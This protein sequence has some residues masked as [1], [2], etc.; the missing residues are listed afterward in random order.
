M[1]KTLIIIGSV[2]TLIIILMIAI[3]VIYKGKIAAIAKKTANNAVN[4]K[5]DFTDVDI[6]LFRHFPHL[7]VALKNLTVTGIGDFGNYKL[8]QA[9]ALSTSVNL[10][11]L[12]KKNLSIS[13]IYIDKPVLNLKV[14]KAG[15]SNWDI[16]KTDTTKTETKK[17]NASID[18]NK[19]HI[20]DASLTYN[21][22]GTPMSFSLSNA[23]FD[24][25]GKMKGSNST[26]DVKGK[27]D[28]LSFDYNGTNYIKNLK[29]AVEGQLKADFN[30]KVFTF[31][32]NQ[33]LI[34]KLPLEADGTFTL[35]EKDYDFDINFKSPAS[36]L[37]DLLG[38]I[39]EKYHSYV[40]D[41]QTQ[42]SVSFSGYFKG[43]YND[44]TFPGF[45]VDIKVNDGKLKYPKLPK[46]IEQINIAANINKA[47]GDMDLAK[48][49]VEKFE[50][51]LAGNPIDASLH[52]AT[53]VSDPLVKGNLKGKIDFTELKQAIPMDS[54][55]LGGIMEAFID[56]DGKYSSIEK[57]QYQDFKTTGKVTLRNFEY[58]SPSLTQRVKIANAGMDF[59]PKTI[60]LTNL[61]GS[62]GQSDFS[63]KG[64]LSNYWLYVMKKGTLSGDLNL[65]SRYLDFNVLKPKS[66]SSVKDTISKPFEVPDKINLT[67]NTAINQLVFDKLNISNVT[68]KA[69]V[70]DK[71]LILDGLNM[72]MLGGSMVMSG[73]YNTPKEQIPSFNLKMNV[74]NFDLP[75]AFQSVSTIR[76]LV[77]L[78]GESTGAFNT[79]LSI[80]GKIGKGYTPVFTSL[81]GDGLL[82]TKNVQIAGASIFN[83]ISKYF[84]KDLF[85]QVKIGDLSTRFKIVDGGLAVSPFTT[86]I[87]G[88]EVTVSGKQ[89]ASK[90]LSYRLDF[91]VNK[92]DLSQEVNKY[93]GFVPGTEN[94]GLI[95]V[96]IEINGTITKPDVKVDMSDAR[97]L[98]ETEF[99]KKAGNELKD[100]V[101]KLGLDKLFK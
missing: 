81:N 6:S 46:Q 65:N 33:F 78:A 45:N 40:K 50:A 37:A 101:K 17:S 95:P 97:K 1:K 56:F 69:I 43:T 47:Q 3:P 88:Q 38:F 16:A 51:S 57:E 94:I 58:G 77:P 42:G 91:K 41:V 85:N 9:D 15:K 36:S 70:R 13:E 27:A 53:P 80:S 98:V 22:E 24:I 89:S 64:A 74:K 10:S 34:N 31:L 7:N 23:I 14:N 29:A 52:V 73:E 67:L 93:I 59:N 100:A 35:G 25:S 55:D 28:S 61:T 12:W 63:A 68:G 90:D 66:Q 11:S 48:V 72:N 2:L 60:T 86:K 96:G 75:T 49:D 8:L 62:M 4:A 18:L 26:L 83:Q 87:A 5:I 54:L 30:K 44:K 79:D 92:S 39:P 21:D 82:S 84:R 32:K 19:I 76:Y 99:K 71:K 20:Q